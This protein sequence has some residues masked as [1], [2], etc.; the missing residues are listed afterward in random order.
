[1]FLN[2]SPGNVHS[3]GA[4]WHISQLLYLLY[5][6]LLNYTP[7]SGCC[8]I[9][10]CF[11]RLEFHASYQITMVSASYSNAICKL[12]NVT[13]L[14]YFLSIHIHIMAFIVWS[15]CCRKLYQFIKNSLF[16]IQFGFFLTYKSHSKRLKFCSAVADNYFIH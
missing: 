2:Y 1:M 4:E 11:R 9:W 16:F 14:C 10:G 12:I 7:W 15:A 13:L 8:D 5:K 3:D 6:L